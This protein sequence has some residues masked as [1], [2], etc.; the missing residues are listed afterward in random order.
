MSER[1]IRLEEIIDAPA[2]DVW[3]A[4]TTVEGLRTF[5]AP[6]AVIDVKA[7][8]TWE[9]HFDPAAPEGLRGSEGC[10]VLEV[11]K[12]RLLVFE[13]NFVPGSPIRDEKTT[14]AVE[15]HAFGD[16]QCQVGL[17]VVGW[18]EGADWDAGFAYFS[19]AWSLVLARLDHS[20]SAGP[21]DWA[22]PWRPPA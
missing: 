15:I 6:E 21:I 14:V 1:F 19:E 16:A 7:G 8:G 11:K 18:K 2:A 17:E 3:K 5:L 20:F 12:G 9:I 4:W 22:N 10:K 13:W